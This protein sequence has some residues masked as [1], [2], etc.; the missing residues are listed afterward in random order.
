MGRL[1]EGW[2][3]YE[4][5]W[6]NPVPAHRGAKSEY[7][8]WDGSGLA[9][10]SILLHAEQGLG[11]TIQFIRYAPMVNASMATGGQVSVI[12]QPALH[13][14]FKHI[15]GVNSW[16]AQGGALPP[17][18]LHISLLSLPRIFNTT[19]ETVPAPI[20]YLK[21]EPLLVKQ[22]S[23]RLAA[24]GDGSAL[25]VG[26][27]WRGNPDNPR[28]R[29]RSIGLEPLLPLLELPG[30]QFFALQVGPGQEEIAALDANLT[31]LSGQLTDFAHTAAALR[32]LD[33]LISA[34]TATAHLA[35][36]LGCPGWIMSFFAH[37]F[38]WLKGREDSPWY[39]S[40]R[41]FHQPGIGQWAP[42]VERLKA[43]LAQHPRL[44]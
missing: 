6:Q 44:G 8:S 5:R 40:L 30:I 9:G 24:L 13:R 43:A 34:D 26:L 16:H 3:E 22:W 31:D 39:P 14:L 18:D 11:D 12:C 29:H 36:A 20:P 15:P 38:R 33:L 42:V 1:E 25:K 32:N 23:E 7:P 27:V 19:V 28:D 41:L 4:W 21:A 10:R 17:A 37:D 2:R 35:G